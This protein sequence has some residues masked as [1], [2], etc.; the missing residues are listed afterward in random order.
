MY[1]GHCSRLGLLLRTPVTLTG[2]SCSNYPH[3]LVGC[4]RAA[5]CV[6]SRVREVPVAQPAL[7]MTS[8]G[9]R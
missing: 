1:A 8:G 5:T 3:P 4:L 9:E 6:F 2:P 7:Q